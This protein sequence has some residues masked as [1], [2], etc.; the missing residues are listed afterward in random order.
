LHPI[1]V[2]E[3]PKESLDDYP[4]EQVYDSFIC[5]CFEAEFWTAR[6][7]LPTVDYSPG[8]NGSLC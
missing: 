2:A 4:A 5:T 6:P 8:T 7:G 3:P 1:A